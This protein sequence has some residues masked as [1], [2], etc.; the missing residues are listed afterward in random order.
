MVRL[1]AKFDV[2]L[3][4]E[5]P[6]SRNRLLCLTNKIL[7]YMLAGSAIVA[8]LTPGQE[9]VLREVGEAAEGYAFG[10]IESL[11]AA[12]RRWHN[13]RAALDRARRQSWFWGTQ[14]YNWD[15]EKNIFLS[16]V[17]HT[18]AR[19]AESRSAAAGV[20]GERAR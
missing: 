6:I 2:G 10:N 11:A 14:R 19:T 3:A 9:P 18:L 12:L 20:Q 17:Q 8:T 5:Q 16:L 4:L 7:T 1:A 13:D 15:S